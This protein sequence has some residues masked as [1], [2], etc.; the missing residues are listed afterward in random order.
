M[1]RDAN[2]ING[3]EE[4]LLH[5]HSNLFCLSYILPLCP[6]FASFSDSLISFSFLSFP[7]PLYLSFFSY[8]P[9]LFLFLL[10]LS[11]SPYFSFSLDLLFPS[12]FSL[13]LPLLSLFSSSE[14]CLGHFSSLLFLSVS[15]VATAD[16]R[17][18]DVTKN[19]PNA[20]FGLSG[21]HQ[22]IFLSS[23]SKKYQTHKRRPI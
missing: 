7:L 10:Y 1:L 15:V 3:L 8:I 9:Y 5:S 2:G 6:S 12:C 14:D 23:H 19:N 16:L 20:R 4:N 22:I 11:L 13:W 17:P 21:V 18:C